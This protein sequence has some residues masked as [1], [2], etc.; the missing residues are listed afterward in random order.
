M[1]KWLNDIHDRLRDYEQEPPGGLWDSLHA[2][3]RQEGLPGKRQPR[4]SAW[5]VWTRRAGV[6]ACIAVAALAGY[7]HMPD[8]GKSAGTW[9]A[10]IEEGGIPQARTPRRPEASVAEAAP[11][12]KATTGS[13]RHEASRAPVLAEAAIKATPAARAHAASAH[14]AVEVT[15]EDMAPSPRAGQE[16]KDSRQKS[17]TQ[18]STPT[19][20]GMGSI[21]PRR[22]AAPQASHDAPQADSRSRLQPSSHGTR[23]PHAR[24]AVAAYATGMGS[25]EHLARGTGGSPLTALGPDAAAWN[26]SPQ[27]ALAVFNR[28]RATERVT[29]HRLPVRVGATVTYDLTHHLALGS[30]LTYTRLRSDLREGTETNYQRSVQSLHYVGLP[31][32]VRYTFLRYKRLG[33]YAQAGVLAEVRVAGTLTTRYTLDGH[34][35]HEGTNRIGSHPLQMS[36]GAALGAQYSLTPALALYAEPGVS[37][38]FKDNSSV[39]TIYGDKPTSFTLNVGVSLCLGR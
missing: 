37:H 34:T 23:P 15:G 16:G 26:D 24:L 36:A 4:A 22:S 6:A 38:Y 18:V 39:P 8:S 35:G 3:L 32:N 17:R 14:V 11:Q 31:V 10:E 25:S 13:A 1:D 12:A 33:L 30:G 29:R 7:R 28:G 9:Q 19:S 27:L 21:L 2:R 20:T 5:M